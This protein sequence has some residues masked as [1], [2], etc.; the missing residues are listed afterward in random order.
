V[1]ATFI[2]ANVRF[3]FGW[4]RWLLATP[5]FHHWHHSAETVAVDKNFAV[6]LPALDWL[7]GTY[8]LPKGRWPS[9]YGLTTGLTPPR[10]YL[11]QFIFPWLPRRSGIVTEEHAADALE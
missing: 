1:Q 11:R 10:G 4:L 3:E 5:Q 8:Y 6:H 7:F 9:S 2:H